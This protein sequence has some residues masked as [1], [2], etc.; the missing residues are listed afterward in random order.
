MANCRFLQWRDAAVFPESSEALD[1]REG[2]SE[3]LIHFAPS[4]CMTPTHACLLTMF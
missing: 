1:V 3:H 4:C 2:N